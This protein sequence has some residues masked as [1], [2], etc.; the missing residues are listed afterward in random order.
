MAKEQIFYGYRSKLFMSNRDGNYLG[1]AA[2]NKYIKLLAREILGK[3]VTTHYMRHTHVALLA[4]QD[5][6]LDAIARR[7]G[8]SD[9]QIT[10]RIYFHVTEK[11]KEKDNAQ[12]QNIKII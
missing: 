5:V 3:D 2:Y 10:K 4:E 1:Y 8:H 9:S 11:L 6:T 12:I 7:L